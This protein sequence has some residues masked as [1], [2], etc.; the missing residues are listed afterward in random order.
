[1]KE[2]PLFIK[3]AHESKDY[4]ASQNIKRAHAQ[5]MEMEQKLVELV[6]KDQRLPDWFEDKLSK[7]ADDV[8]ELYNFFKSGKL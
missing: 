7:I 8:E 5:L 6:E 4:M 2:I 1:M 3:R